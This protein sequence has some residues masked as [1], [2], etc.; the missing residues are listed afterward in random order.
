MFEIISKAES[1]NVG[2]G[3]HCTHG[4]NRTGVVIVL[5]LI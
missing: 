2:V 4:R 3:I 5:Y 1:E